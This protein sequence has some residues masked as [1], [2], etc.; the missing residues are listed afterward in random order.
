MTVVSH[1][2]GDLSSCRASYVKQIPKA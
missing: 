2:F 1:L